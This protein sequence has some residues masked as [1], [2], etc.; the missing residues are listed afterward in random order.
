MYIHI[1]KHIHGARRV[2]ALRCSAGAARKRMAV[3]GTSR[4]CAHGRGPCAAGSGAARADTLLR[5]SVCQL[6]F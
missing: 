1:N 5:D 3:H 4:E 6:V 2:C